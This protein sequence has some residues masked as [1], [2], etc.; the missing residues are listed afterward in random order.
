MVMTMNNSN[1]KTERAERKKKLIDSGAEV[2]AD[3]LLTLADRDEEANEYINFALASTDKKIKQV[4]SKLA[5]LK[6]LSDYIDYRG[7]DQFA[8]K[9]EAILDELE[10]CQ[11]EPETGMRLVAEFMETDSSV[12]EY[13][14]DSYGSVGYVYTGK[15][16]ELFTRYGAACEDKKIVEDILLQTLREDSY[17]A[18]GDMLKCAGVVLPEKNLRHMFEYWNGKPVKSRSGKLQDWRCQA[19]LEELARQL[20]DPD[21]F[22]KLKKE[23]TGG[24][25]HERDFAKIAQLYYDCGD[26]VNA[27]DWLQKAPENESAADELRKKLYGKLGMRDEI[28]KMCREEF[29]EFPSLNTLN[30]LLAV[31]GK[32]KKREVIEE[33]IAEIKQNKKFDD[34][35]L[36]FLVETGHLEDASEYV[37]KH[38]ESVDGNS[39]YVLGA[40][41]ETLTKKEF[42]L[43]ATIILRALLS[44]ILERKYA[45]A[46]HHGADYWKELSKIAP[47]ISDWRGLELH[48]DYINRLKADHKRKSGFWSRVNE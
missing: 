43:A 38:R 45:K 34:I 4:Q 9:L 22:I 16:V 39:Y 8:D 7:A 1:W 48:A 26:Y 3:I 40:V 33:K 15:A 25:V 11:V 29:H 12:F 27:L 46:Y 17:G 6:H 18:R 36:K 32:G 31:I 30:E 10:Q 35:D 14:D 24:V 37:I 44:S 42:F 20:K 28:E 13:C 5:G 41:A 23:K 21:L 47:E 2:L 19:V